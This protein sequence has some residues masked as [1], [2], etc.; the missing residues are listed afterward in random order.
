M[1]PLLPSSPYTRSQEFV[2]EEW[3]AIFA[4]NA[5][6]P[7]ER[8]TGGWK[9]VL[10]ANLALIDPAASWQFFAQDGFDY[11][12][13]DGGASRTW[14]LAFAAGKFLCLQLKPSSQRVVG[15]GLGDRFADVTQIGLGGA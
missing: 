13:I 10:Y 2:R 12:W 9:G 6:A 1:L 15:P 4:T 7:A 3:D 14:Y 11:G 8:V 5:A